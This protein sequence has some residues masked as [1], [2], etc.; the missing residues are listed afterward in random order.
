MTGVELHPRITQSQ[1]ANMFGEFF[2]HSNASGLPSLPRM[3][4]PCY[5]F[6]GPYVKIQNS[7][8]IVKVPHEEIWSCVMSPTADGFDINNGTYVLKLHISPSAC[9]FTKADDYNS[10]DLQGSTGVVTLLLPSTRP[11]IFTHTVQL[12]SVEGAQHSLVSCLERKIHVP[13]PWLEEYQ[14]GP[15]IEHPIRKI[16]P[17]GVWASNAGM[18]IVKRF[19]RLA[20]DGKREIFMENLERLEK[21]ADKNPKY[22]D[23]IPLV[24]YELALLDLHENCIE[25]A[26]THAKNALLISRTYH[27]TNHCYLLT[28][29]KYVESALARREG[30]YAKAKELLDDSVELLLPCAA[31]EETAENRYFIASFYVEK[32]AR[33]GI[34]ESEEAITENCFQDIERHLDAEIRPITNRFQIRAKNRRLA[35]YVKSSRHVKNLDFQQSVPEEHMAKASHLIREI[36]ERL[37]SFYLKKA[38]LSFDIVKTDFF[39]R[40]GNFVR[41]IAPSREALAIAQEKQWREYEDVAKQRLKLCCRVRK[42]AQGNSV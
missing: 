41:G 9:I 33:A 6:A 8:E 11:Q 17:R 34:T 1:R 2:P 31:G 29:L 26:K 18:A 24:F 25:A 5:P 27:S 20:D 14:E 16:R 32:S 12:Y 35:F 4:I 7:L 40:T 22:T 39:I 30:Q 37:L 21:F 13:G 23:L 28:K 42:A 38:L 19:Q 15:A 10:R 3:S 36:E